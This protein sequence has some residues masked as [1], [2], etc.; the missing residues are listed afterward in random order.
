MAEETCPVASRINTL[1]K[2]TLFPSLRLCLVRPRRS[3][4]PS[5]RRSDDR[6]VSTRRFVE[7]QRRIALNS[8]VKQLQPP[9]STSSHGSRQ[10]DVDHRAQIFI[11]NVRSQLRLQPQVSLQSRYCHGEFLPPPPPESPSI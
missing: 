6:K 2:L 3:R 4:P 5:P 7:A 9:T 1:K 8:S 11:H 10:D